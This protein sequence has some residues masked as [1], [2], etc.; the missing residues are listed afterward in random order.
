M[1]K[2]I[3]DQKNIN[4]STLGYLLLLTSSIVR[5]G[6][7]IYIPALPVIGKDLAISDADMNLTLTVYFTVFSLF[8]LICGPLSDAFGRKFLIQLGAVVFIIGSFI[9]G[10]STSLSYLIT[11][12]IIQAI[13]ASMI[14]GTSRAMIRDI[15]SDTEVISLLGWMAVLGGLL[16]VG[17]PI[18]G[19]FITENY[20]WSYNFWLL[21]AFT[22]LILIIISYFLPETLIAEKRIKLNL[23]PVLITYKKMMLAPD[24]FLVILPVALCF[25]IQGVYL[26]TAPF[27][28]IKNFMMTPA[29]FGLSNIAIVIALTL[30]RYISVNMVKYYSNKTAYITGAIITLIAGGM[31]TVVGIGGYEN[32]Y[33]LLIGISIFGIGF[34]TIAPI[35]LKSSITAFRKTSGMAAALQGCLVLGG[36]AIGSAGIALMMQHSELLPMKILSISMA[37]VTA[38]IF[39]TAL[40]SKEKL[41]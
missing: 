2:K 9:C 39:F 24:F 36:T 12:R 23:T 4:V 38:F 5:M 30:G 35:G 17:A 27:I 1:Y 21:V 33:T 10:E 28:F 16:M 29:Q 7:C 32:I 6:A 34:G 19:G 15:A 41:V 22:S 18:L 3:I 14:P 20:H 8:I 40:I 26:A 31:F 37:I 25:V 13:G 11:G